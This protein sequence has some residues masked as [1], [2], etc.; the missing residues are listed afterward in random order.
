[1]DVLIIVGGY[2]GI[3]AA[4]YFTSDE[5]R[6]RRRRQQGYQPLPSTDESSSPGS[7]IRPAR[8]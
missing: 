4:D 8:M 6:T 2:L 7:G 3:A 1:M 5:F